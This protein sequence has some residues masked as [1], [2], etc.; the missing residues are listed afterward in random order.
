MLADL[1]RADVL[2]IAQD[3]FGKQPLNEAFEDAFGELLPDEVNINHYLTIVAAHLDP[4]SERVVRYLEE[5]GVPINAVFFAYLAD[6]DRRY[7][8]RSWLLNQEEHTI[9]G[10]TPGRKSKLAPWSGDWYISF[11]DG[12]GRRPQ[13]QLRVGWRWGLVL[14]DP[15]EAAREVSDLRAHPSS[16]ICGGGAVDR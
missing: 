9:G 13:V 15:A 5:F 8:A 16:R 12:L 7:L 11:G 4:S 1:Q 10:T 3:H 14:K 6:G 2:E